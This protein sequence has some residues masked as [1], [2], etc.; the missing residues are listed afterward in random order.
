MVELNQIWWF[1]QKYKFFIN[2]PPPSHAGAASV[3][4][5]TNLDS[6][7]KYRQ[8]CCCPEKCIS[9]FLPRHDPAKEQ[10]MMTK[11]ET[12]KLLSKC[13]FKQWLD[14]GFVDR[15]YWPH[16]WF[17]SNPW[18]RFFDPSLQL[19]GISVKSWRPWR[20]THNLQIWG[21]PKRGIKSDFLV[22][23]T[24]LILFGK[25]LGRMPGN[26]NLEAHNYEHC[27]FFINTFKK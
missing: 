26:S 6:T 11:E 23:Q 3:T 13:H 20:W 19:S 22:T 17:K 27:H 1:Q 21:G 25:V 15:L 16:F 24:Y 18:Q 8:W 7:F 14:D 5:S 9:W 2:S 4:Y 10:R 12:I